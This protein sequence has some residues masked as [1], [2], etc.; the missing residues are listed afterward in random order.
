MTELDRSITDLR[1]GAWWRIGWTVTTLV[2]VEIVVCGLS[3]M[4]ILMLWSR[5]A[6]I[7]GASVR[8]QIVAFSGAIVPSY[9][10]FAIMLLI[11]SPLLTRLAGWRTP[12]DTEM[13]IADMDWPLLNW[14]RYAASNHL[15][16]VLAGTVFRGSPLWTAHLR[17][18]GAKLGKRVYVNS[19]SINDYNLLEFGDDVVIGAGVHLSGHTVEGGIV[20]TASVRLGRNTTVGVGSVIEIGVEAGPNCEIGA[21]SLVPK[22]TQLEAEA[23]YAGI[24][25]KRI[26]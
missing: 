6:R 11:V 17:L 2:L 15:V 7:A 26:R 16:R 25:A 14:V 18:A 8:L 22:R 3:A 9:V 21:L 1:I 20:K 10:T 13:R 12:V 4:P 19:L 23:V 24:P 5:L